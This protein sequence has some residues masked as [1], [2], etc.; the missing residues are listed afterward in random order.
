[1]KRST[2]FKSLL[3]LFTLP[4]LT[5]FCKKEDFDFD[6]YLKRHPNVRVSDIQLDPKRPLAIEYT[7]IDLPELGTKKVIDIWHKT[8]KLLHIDSVYYDKQYHGLRY[9]GLIYKSFPI[10]NWSE[11]MDDMIML[12]NEL[13]SKKIFVAKNIY[14]R[15]KEIG[16]EDDRIVHYNLPEDHVYLPELHHRGGVFH[17]DTMSEISDPKYRIDTIHGKPSLIEN[18]HWREKKSE[19]IKP[20]S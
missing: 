7:V 14:D 9:Y 12:A 3:A 10:K 5:G 2:F 11:K 1:M 18:F 16:Y 19:L 8:G 15:L 17:I 13:E 6:G 20:L 4:V